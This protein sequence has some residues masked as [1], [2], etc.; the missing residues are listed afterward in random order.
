MSLI[1]KPRFVKPSLFIT[2]VRPVT[3]STSPSPPSLITPAVNTSENI[4]QVQIK[5]VMAKPNNF[6][7]KPNI[8]AL[9]K[10]GIIQTG[11]SLENKNSSSKTSLTPTTQT[12]QSSIVPENSEF[13]NTAKENV[14]ENLASPVMTAKPNVGMF[15]K[16]PVIAAKTGQLSVSDRKLSF[17]DNLISSDYD[18][19]RTKDFEF[20]NDM[21]V[22]YEP[23]SKCQSTDAAIPLSL[24]FALRKALTRMVTETGMSVDEYVAKKC[25]WTQEELSTY[26]SAE[27]VDGVALSLFACDRGM[28]EIVADMTGFGKGRILA[29]V[30]RAQILAGRN[31]IFLTEKANLFSDFWRDIEDINST[32]VYGQP[33]ILN[34][35]AKIV[36]LNSTANPPPTIW[37]S[38]KPAVVNEVLKS[39]NLPEGRRFMMATYSQ[40][41]RRGT[42]KSKALPLLMRDAF[43]GGDEAHNMA[44]DSATRETMTE[45]KKNSVAEIYSSATYARKIENM[46]VYDR[47]F[48]WLKTIKTLDVMTANQKRMLAE[49][50]NVAAVNNGNIIRREHDLSEMNL[51]LISD[52]NNIERNKA[53]ADRLAPILSAMSKLARRVNKEIQ[54]RNEANELM[55]QEDKKHN[56]GFYIAPNFGLKFNAINIQFMTA[57]KVDL[58]IERCIE[59][60]KQNKRPVVVIE[61]TMESLM[62]ELSSDKEGDDETSFDLL[63][64]ED[65]TEEQSPKPPSFNDA[66]NLMLDRIVNVSVRRGGEKTTEKFSNARIDKLYEEIKGLIDC[67]PEISLSPMDDVIEGVERESKKLHEAGQLP[68]V[69]EVEEISAR[70]MCVRNG[71]YLKMKKKDRNEAVSNFVN[72]RKKCCIVTRAASTGLSLHDSPKFLDHSPK[73]LI[74]LSASQDVLVRAQTWGRVWR[75]GQLSIPEFEVLSSGLRIEQK[76][77]AAQNRKMRDMNSSVTG[78]S[79]TKGQVKIDDACDPIGNMLA[80]KFFEDN[81]ALAEKMFVYM[82]IDLDDPERELY[83]INKLM[84][85]FSFIQT[86]AG[87]KIYDNFMAIYHEYMEHHAL[88][89]DGDW[90]IVDRKLFQPGDGTNDPVYGAPVLLTKIRRTEI[91]KPYV[92]SEVIE[93]IERGKRLLQSTGYTEK[94]LR[95]YAQ[96]IA[97]MKEDYLKERLPKKYKNLRMALLDK[98]SAIRKLSDKIDAAMLILRKLEP[99]CVFA[100]P[101][102]ESLTERAVVTNIRIPDIADATSFTDYKIELA[103]PGQEKIKSLSLATLLETNSDIQLATD[104]AARDFLKEFVPMTERVVE[105]MV[106]DGNPLM[107]ALISIDLNFG[108]VFTYDTGNKQRTG[109]LVPAG[110]ENKLAAYPMKSRNIKKIC[111]VLQAGSSVYAGNNREIMLYES[112]G[113]L[114]LITPHTVEFKKRADKMGLL[115]HIE[116]RGDWTETYAFVDESQ[117]PAILKV[118]IDE[119]G[120]VNIES[121][122]RTSASALKVF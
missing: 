51:K 8:A 105:R 19:A 122:Y 26:L 52:E 34:N 40:F 46:L 9:V 53:M 49:A 117:T 98:D 63:E 38:D 36:D 101:T 114:K 83:Y 68:W 71:E 65:E 99:G 57:L 37:K 56:G 13:V 91:V 84:N 110:Q 21:Q 77:I 30:G 109:I 62:R 100:A 115:E 55:S 118:L 60:L 106:L 61:N 54:D 88:T 41:N 2:G 25:Q 58:C 22:K 29:T 33:F 48:P 96:K 93:M 86:D 113:R 43:V 120:A 107:A 12:S 108:R 76:L 95:R 31:F 81:P 5:N 103:V 70:S 89:M 35:G 50:S 3:P 72:G 15:V 79:R 47:I 121:K 45:S 94:Q 11:S 4:T 75:R 87:N 16:K 42:L 112:R 64:E 85:G 78:T 14:A 7:K 27:Q 116:L 90:E 39:G 24:A 1:N 73:V 6:I 119:Y 18:D 23:F 111:E 59:A 66:L 20:I 28:S 32:D 104:G 17:Y 44:G 69:C 102:G 74:E 67:F 80:K 10:S 82:D 92:T 97:E